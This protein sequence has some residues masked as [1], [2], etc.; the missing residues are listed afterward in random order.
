MS[1][2][3]PWPRDYVGQ[4]RDDLHFVRTL[5][6]AVRTLRRAPN[7]HAYRPDELAEL[8][9]SCAVIEASLDHAETTILQAIC[10]WSNVLERTC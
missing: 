2:T 9:T 3:S 10:G 5:R 4:L 8:D 7:L 6:Y 1:D